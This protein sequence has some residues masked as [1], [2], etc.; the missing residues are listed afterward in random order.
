MKRTRVQCWDHQLLKILFITCV[1]V[2]FPQC[3]FYT[4]TLYSSHSSHLSLSCPTFVRSYYSCKFGRMF[5]IYIA[6]E[7]QTSKL[8]LIFIFIF[9]T[10]TTVYEGLND[11]LEIVRIIK[12]N[13]KLGFLY[14]T[15]AVP[16]SSIKYHPYN[17]KVV[18]HNNINHQDFYTISQTGRSVR[19]IPEIQG[20]S[21]RA[22]SSLFKGSLNDFF[23]QK[24]YLLDVT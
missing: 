23:S 6:K 20:N 12:E 19:Q 11:P 2:L 9:L 17:L 3:R 14:L 4:I 10:D 5:G 21:I 24:Y 22:I 8:K 13:P 18:A 16:K 7:Q 1:Y 15:P